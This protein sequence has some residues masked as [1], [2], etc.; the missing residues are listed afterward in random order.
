MDTV[1]SIE[2][3][4]V[5]VLLLWF[6]SLYM[7]RNVDHTMV[8]TVTAILIKANEDVTDMARVEQ[9]LSSYFRY[10]CYEIQSSFFY[11]LIY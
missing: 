3:S 9:Q 10:I 5:R 6:L 1:S 2:I 4:L 7:R 8:A 11:L